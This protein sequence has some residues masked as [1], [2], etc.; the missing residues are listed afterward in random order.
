MVSRERPASRR[1][2]AL[3]ASREPFV[4]K[5]SSGPGTACLSCCTNRSKSLRSKGSPPV[6]RS[7]SVPKLVKTPANQQIGY[8][9]LEVKIEP[10]EVGDH[11][12][13]R[14]NGVAPVQVLAI[15]RG[16]AAR[17][18]IEKKPGL[19]VIQRSNSFTEQGGLLPQGL[20]VDVWAGDVPADLVLQALNELE[21]MTPKAGIPQEV[22]REIKPGMGKGPRI[23]MD[24]DRVDPVAIR[25]MLDAEL[26]KPRP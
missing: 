18:P 13:F 15:I 17:L 8:V 2:A 7:F 1:A 4:V 26:T 19:L 16:Q 9:D 6:R 14:F 5:V 3:A 23:A 25:D 10:G 12:T 24:L 22:R 20:F 11:F 21:A